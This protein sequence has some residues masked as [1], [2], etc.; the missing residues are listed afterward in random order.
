MK[1]LTS[2]FIALTMSSFVLSSSNAAGVPDEQFS[3]SSPTDGIPALG[4][5]VEESQ[6][7]RGVF[8]KLQAFTAD[9]NIRM[10]SKVTSVATCIQYGFGDCT[11]NKFFFYH[12]VLGM[13]KDSAA[14]DCVSNVS[15]K[16]SSGNQLD[17]KFVE[18]FPG[19]TPYEY[20]GD[21]AANL[22]SGSS[23]FIVDIPGAPHDGGTKYLVNVEL[24]GE[25]Q[26]GQSQFYVNQFQA[27][28]FAVRKDAGSYSPPSPSLKAS[29]F[30]FYGQDSYK[31]IS[32]SS[33]GEP[34]SC[35]QSSSSFCAN[36][37]PMPQNV[38]FSLGIKLHTRVSGWLHGR[39]NNSAA[40][41]SNTSDGNQLVEVSGNPAVVPALIAWQHRA[42]LPPAIKAYYDAN[43][44]FVCQ[45]TGFGG[46]IDGSSNGGVCNA[47]YMLRELTNFTQQEMDEF[48]LWLP[49]LN[50]TAPYAPTQWSVQ[51]MQNNYN[52][53]KNCFKD[54]SQLSG[55]VATNSAMYI[56]GPPTFN[57]EDQSLDYKVASPH[58][59]PDHSVFKGTYNLV[60]RS[61]V[62]RCIYGFSSAPIKAAVSIQSSDG[63]SQVAST[64]LTESNGWL[65][66]S[67]NGFTFSN[68]TI[69]VKL[70]QDEPVVAPV[71]PVPS[72]VVVAKPSTLAKKI[73]ISCLK[74]KT[75]KKVTALKPTCPSGYK[76]K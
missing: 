39:L 34:L 73:T 28:I 47:R 24:S 5:V 32:T 40:N 12:A 56:S 25:K 4:I 57:S 9:G 23:T 64:T 21:P 33:N 69:H 41:I 7:A 11:S 19:R 76:R 14:F 75:T 30:Q 55:L 51:S 2:V 54:A 48:L 27:A 66:L 8:S 61:D 31:R 74:G 68:P 20:V 17:V 10:K 13:C 49:T 59:L 70:S 46:N 60:I 6:H 38:T 43:P 26:E 22:P 62:A 44:E 63:G 29:D 67:A 18:E 45:G 15:A 72:D 53:P 65:S 42:T 36:A 58:Y 35:A 16:D 50:D 52:D 3:L 71:N 1:K 37:F